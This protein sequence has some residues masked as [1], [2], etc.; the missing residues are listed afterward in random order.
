MRSDGQ[1]P[2]ISRISIGIATLLG[3]CT[4]KMNQGIALVSLLS[5]LFYKKRISL[6]TFQVISNHSH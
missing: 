6:G 4:D 1:A 5:K 2:Y 3:T